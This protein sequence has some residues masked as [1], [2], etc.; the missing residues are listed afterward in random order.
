MTGLSN[1]KAYVLIIKEM[2]EIMSRPQFSEGMA[3]AY[4]KIA[5]ER[6]KSLIKWFGALVSSCLQVGPNLGLTVKHLGLG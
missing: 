6:A 2:L 4:R 5:L 3:F 1:G